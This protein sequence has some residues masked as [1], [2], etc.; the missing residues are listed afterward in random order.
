MNA[1]NGLSVKVCT[2][3][4]K[5]TSFPAG[6]GTQV[7]RS[8]FCISSINSISGNSDSKS[9]SPSVLFCSFFTYCTACTL[10]KAFGAVFSDHFIHSTS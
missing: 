2:E 1:I 4:H 3:I 5:V 7:F 9:N 10:D 8:G 6:D